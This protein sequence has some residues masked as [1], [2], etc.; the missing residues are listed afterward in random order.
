MRTSEDRRLTVLLAESGRSVGGT[1][2]VVWELATRLSPQRFAVRVWLSDA[3]GVN[4]FAEALQG[5]GI[6]VDRI[7]EVDS[8]WDWKGMLRTWNALRRIE[9]DVLH[10][11]HVWPAADRYLAMLARAAG[12]KRLVVTEHIVGT[13]HSG[14][15]RALKRDEIE[16]ADAVTAVCGAIAET[17][18]RDYGVSREQIRIVP[19]GADLPDEAAEQPVARRWRERFGAS[20]IRPL[21]VVPARLEEQKGHA[22][23]FAALAEI[24]KRGLD[25]SVALAGDGSLRNDLEQRALSLGLANKIHFL[26]QLEDVGSLLTAADAVVLPSLW[27]GLPLALLEALVRARPVTATAVGGVPEVLEDDVHGQLVPPGDAIALADALERF[28]RKPDRAM[29]LGRTGAERVR[30]DFTWRAV[31][32]G[33][34]GLYDDVCGLATFSPA[35]SGRAVAAGTKRGGGR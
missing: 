3:P 11:H 9:P 33:F 4:E 34:E 28:H 16:R 30:A 27:E 14:G 17:L 21:W 15:Q 29:R 26:G 35:E 7:A 6:A 1:E 10:V 20:L 31:V 2:R 32:Q 5:R 19:N 24:W 13:S 22:V 8:R 25:F 12:V 18:V 23:L